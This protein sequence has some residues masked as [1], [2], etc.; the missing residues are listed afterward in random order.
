MPSWP[1]ESAHLLMPALASGSTTTVPGDRTGRRRPLQGTLQANQWTCSCRRP[2]RSQRQCPSRLPLTT[3]TQPWNATPWWHPDSPDERWRT[4]RTSARQSR[5]EWRANRSASGPAEERAMRLSQVRSRPRPA[6]PIHMNA[7]DG[8][9]ATKAYRGLVADD[10]GGHG[11]H[12]GNHAHRDRIKKRRTVIAWRLHMPRRLRSMCAAR[13][14]RSSAR[15]SPGCSREP[16]GCET[17][18]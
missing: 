16:S 5:P 4:F 14:A 12:R 6:P 13:R 11:Q 8:A 7:D 1:K 9:V 17:R 10:A 15:R 2:H 3:R 18:A